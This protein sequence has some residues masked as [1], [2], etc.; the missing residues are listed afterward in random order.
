MLVT[1]LVLWMV[2]VPLATV[3]G[4]YILS[5]FFSRRARP[6]A[7]DASR[8]D[9]LGSRGLTARAGAV[10]HLAVIAGSAASRLRDH[11]LSR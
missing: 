2:V 8:I 4:M 7:V 1:L 5:G 9:V 10:H 3:V 11:R 6:G